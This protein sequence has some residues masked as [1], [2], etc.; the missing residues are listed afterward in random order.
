MHESR[1]STIGTG[2]RLALAAI[3]L[4]LY[5]C[6][7]S[8]EP[9][10]PQPDSSAT[11]AQRIVCGTPAITEIVFA[12]GCADRVIGV[13]DFSTF[14]PEANAKQS[15]GGW[16]S[17]NRERL[18]LLNPDLILTQGAHKRLAAFAEEYEIP[19]HSTE[20][21]SLQDTYCAIDTLAT[22]LDV[23]TRGN[24]LADQIQNDIASV[25]DTIG[26]AP[27]KR[28]L[29]LLGRSPGDLAGLTAVGPGT[30]LNDLLIT[31]GGTNIF[32]DAIGLYPRVSKES[33]LVRQPETI[34]ELVSGHPS[35][36]AIRAL[37]ADWLQLAD[38]PAVQKNQV[39]C[40]TN[41]VLL[42]PGPRMH[43]SVRLL[44]RAIHPEQFDD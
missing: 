12:L 17:P 36:K 8:E 22:L 13:S 25:R 1:I 43:Q 6:T 30:F 35:D 34:I 7:R 31:A 23:Q 41:D 16:I 3:L 9:L 21:D 44:A 4:S 24:A 29:L 39:H 28:I 2:A 14:P 11:P 5:G 33:I 26:D 37:K 38:I 18:L 20:L 42:I 15:I 40:L 32:A 27:R 19:F 10:R